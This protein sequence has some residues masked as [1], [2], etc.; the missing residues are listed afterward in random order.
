MT[1]P[2]SFSVLIAAYNARAF[3]VDT[4]E[5]VRQQT[6]SHFELVVVDD[7]SADDTVAVVERYREAHPDIRIRIVPSASRGMGGARNLCIREARHDWL[8]FLDHDDLWYP[9]KLERVSQVIR[10]DPSL[11]I[12][13]HDEHLVEK[14]GAGRSRTVR[15]IHYAMPTDRLYERFL[16]DG[17][18]LSGSATVV[19][20]RRVIEAGMFSENPEWSWIADYDLWLKLA[21][22]GCRIRFID[23]VLG[24]YVLHASNMTRKIVTYNESLLRVLNHHFTNWP[25][26]S[27]YD[28]YRMRR[29]KADSLRGAGQQFIR[30]GDWR[31]ALAYLAHSLKQDPLSW[32][33]I[34]V[35]GLLVVR[36]LSPRGQL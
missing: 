2:T 9:S 11:D 20:K 18:T 15:T 8:A 1:E 29:R 26:R 4:L 24:K 34:A 25:S 30:Q 23:D 7:G 12:V 27:L 21:A 17:K 35:S 14:D 13:H 10:Q 16:F 36:C 28:R 6:Y 5:T 22:L 19:R 32:R 33:T 31:A 3:I